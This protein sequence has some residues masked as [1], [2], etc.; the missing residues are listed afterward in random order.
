MRCCGRRFRQTLRTGELYWN[1]GVSIRNHDRAG[2]LAGGADDDSGADGWWKGI[3]DHA[4]PKKY[5]ER[6]SI[7]GK[8]TTKL[9]QYSISC[10]QNGKV[11]TASSKNAREVHADN[12]AANE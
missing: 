2:V 10:R 5:G 8:Y 3:N 1:H 12:D 11:P 6:L 7:D 4:W 9:K